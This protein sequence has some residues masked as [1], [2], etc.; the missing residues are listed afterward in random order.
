MADMLQDRERRLHQMEDSINASGFP[1]VV[2]LV[3]AFGFYSAS[4][5]LFATNLISP[6]LAFLYWPTSTD[7]SHGSNI[8]LVTLVATV[9]GMLFFGHAAD[10]FGRKF[11]YGVELV[12]VI[13]GTLSKLM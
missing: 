12:L 10:C 5:A 9:F 1:T 3:T 7:G 8:D 4:Y 11:L 6:A 2:F 13:F